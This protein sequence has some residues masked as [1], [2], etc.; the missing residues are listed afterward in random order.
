MGIDRA[1]E[2]E[3][4]WQRKMRTRGASMKFVPV[5]ESLRPRHFG[6]RGASEPAIRLC[7][8]QP[9]CLPNGQIDSRSMKF[10]GLR[11]TFDSLDPPGSFGEGTVVNAYNHRQ[12]D[13]KDFETYSILIARKTQW[14]FSYSFGCI[15]YWTVIYG[16]T[17]FES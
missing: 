4:K 11:S 2:E 7:L 1:E 8:N 17:S 13:V 3:E 16:V 6:S 5:K 12:H 9:S 14:K 15:T 10:T